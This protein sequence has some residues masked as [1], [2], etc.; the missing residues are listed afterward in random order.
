MTQTRDLLSRHVGI[1]SGQYRHIRP[2]LSVIDHHAFTITVEMPEDG[3][4]SYRQ[5]SHY[6]WPDGR[7]QDLVFEADF[8]P[9]EDRLVWDN[10]RIAGEMYALDQ[11]TLYL[12]FRFAHDPDVQV[13][14][15]IQLSACGRDRAR[16][17]HWLRKDK[18]E[19]LTL[20]DE[21]R[22]STP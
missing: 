8:A 5:S 16:T 22:G 19:K 4:C 10:G 9:G 14:E 13:C 15:M 11:Q 20:V 21:R 12:H 6:D 17:W 7:T 18:L 1:W 3:S 2:D